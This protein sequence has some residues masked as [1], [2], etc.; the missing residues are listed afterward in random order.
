M[1]FGGGGS[2]SS[3]TKTEPWDEQKPYLQQ[4]FSEAERIYQD[5]P[6]PYYPGKTYAEMSDPTQVG[7]AAQTGIATGGNPLIDSATT[8]AQNIMQGNTGNPWADF[9][10]SGGAGMK[11]TASGQFLNNNPWLDQTFNTA[12]DKVKQ[13]FSESVI[14]ALNASMGGSGNAGSTTHELMLGKAGGELT[15]SLSGLASDI[16]GGDYARERDRMTNAQSGLTS[17]GAGLFG[18]DLSGRLS[19]LGMA[20]GLREAQYGDAAKLREAGGA[21]EDQAS[22]VIEDDINRFNYNQGAD[23]S[24]LQDF[25]SIISGNYGSTS[26]SRQKSG[27][28]GMATGAGALLSLLSMMG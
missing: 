2:Q 7:L 5:G 19:A 17:T 9:L 8:G 16:Y 12:A 20:P 21:Y 13:G 14:P 11:A 15:D 23:L 6:S 22:K 26:T 25:M 18:S 10:S 28:S 27:G 1:G 3:T 4:G 24:S